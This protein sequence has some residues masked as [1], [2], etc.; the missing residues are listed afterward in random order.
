MLSEESALEA[1]SLII[2]DEE[3]PEIKGH[4]LRISNVVHS[5]KQRSRKFD[6]LEEI[7]PFL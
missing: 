2:E 3:N 5:S 1:S 7:P 4:L 6:S